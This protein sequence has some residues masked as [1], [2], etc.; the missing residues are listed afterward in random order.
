MKSI[1]FIINTIKNQQKNISHNIKIR[2]DIISIN[3]LKFVRL[4]GDSGLMASKI[5][6][7]ELFLNLSRNLELFSLFKNLCRYLEFYFINQF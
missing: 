3:R 2:Y 4:S 7:L 5:R 6:I 1:E